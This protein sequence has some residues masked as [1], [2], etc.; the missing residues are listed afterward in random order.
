MLIIFTFI[1]F[2]K[3]KKFEIFFFGWKE[4]NEIRYRNWGRLVKEYILTVNAW[5]LINSM[6]L[7]LPTEKRFSNFHDPCTMKKVERYSQKFKKK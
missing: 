4:E 5:G 7:V 3:K 6:R 1:S 2:K